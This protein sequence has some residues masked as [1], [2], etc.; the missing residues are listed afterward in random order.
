MY[1]SA[2]ARGD[3]SAFVAIGTVPFAA[4][5]ITVALLTG[6][7]GALAAPV[8][9]AAVPA[10]AEDALVVAFI[11]WIGLPEPE[12]RSAKKAQLPPP[13]IASARNTMRKRG[14]SGGRVRDEY[15]E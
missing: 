5:G 6:V 9:A 10:G 15:G 12:P 14:Q 8:P 1:V 2:A 11:V 4:C 13:R 7:P 3:A